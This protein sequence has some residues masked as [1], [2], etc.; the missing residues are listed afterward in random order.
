MANAMFFNGMKRA[1][2]TPSHLRAIQPKVPKPTIA[3]RF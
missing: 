1:Q 3:R 2:I